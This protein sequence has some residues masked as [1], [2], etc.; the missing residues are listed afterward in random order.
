MYFEPTAGDKAAE[1]LMYVQAVYDVVSSRYPCN[2]E[3]CLNLAG[4]QL[5]AE[6]GNSGLDTLEV[7]G[8]WLLP[9]VH[10]IGFFF[11][12]GAGL[13][14]HATAPGAVV[15]VGQKVS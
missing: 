6:Y 4:L 9:V 12:R 11:C 7:G 13:V 2:E 15:V 3:D 5:Q 1:Y 8:R 14:G 10:M